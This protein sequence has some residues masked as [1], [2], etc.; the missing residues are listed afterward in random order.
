MLQR[1]D[2]VILDLD[3]TLVDSAAL[4][5]DL[6]NH[7]LNAGG[8][9]PAPP[10]TVAEAIGLPLAE[11]FRRAA[12]GADAGAI[13][14]L[15]G[16]Y[17]ARADAAEFVRQ[18]RLYADVAATLAELYARAL[19]LVVGTSKGRP[20]TL[21]ILAHCAIA[22]CIDGVVGGDCVRQGKPHPETI[23]HARRL[24]PAAPER[25]LMVGDTTF[26]MQMGKDAG[27]ATC[28]VTYGMH[29][30][31]TLRQLAPDFVIDEFGSLRSLILI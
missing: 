6:V 16:D 20:T 15:C 26:D 23:E 21:D 31:E 8:L 2:L 9:P 27:V 11:V 30:A 12:P 1:F 28:A 3:G 14:S 24:F 5:V 25:T 7:T 18:F 10:R 29:G 4:L 22:H 13:E 19:R 17:R